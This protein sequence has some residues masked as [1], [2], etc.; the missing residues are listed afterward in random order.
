MANI[1][2]QNQNS[3][4]NILDVYITTHHSDSKPLLQD[5][6]KKYFKNKDIAGGVNEFEIMSFAD[7]MKAKCGTEAGFK[8]NLF[9]LSNALDPNKKTIVFIDEVKV[10]DIAEAQDS[11][12]W[13]HKTFNLNLLSKLSTHKH[14]HFVLCMSPSFSN[15]EESYEFAI[16]PPAHEK[17]NQLY[18]P[19]TR[20]YRNNQEIL[21]FLRYYQLQEKNMPFLE[22]IL[23]LMKHFHPFNI[24]ITII[25]IITIIIMF[26]LR[27]F[28]A[29]NNVIPNV[30]VLDRWI[31]RRL[32]EAVG[33]LKRKY[34]QPRRTKYLNSRFARL[35]SNLD[36]FNVKEKDLPPKFKPDQ[37]KWQSVIWVQNDANSKRLREFL[38]KLD[39]CKENVVFLTDMHIGTHCF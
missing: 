23:S 11:S 35:E 19:L 20:R 1:L 33:Y 24:I 34:F 28:L 12:K 22:S 31:E 21:D 29:C 27:V 32:A 26:A 10:N 38:R 5:F 6:Q 17:E 2:N 14:V 15:Y 18:V 25:A 16:K 4:Q 37:T 30:P 36:D 39:L 8:D 7:L 9:L 13:K 3:S